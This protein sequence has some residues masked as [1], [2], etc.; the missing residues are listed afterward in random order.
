MAVAF[1]IYASAQ[2]LVPV[3]AWAQVHANSGDALDH[4]RFAND[5]DAAIERARRSV[6]AG[7]LV[8]AIADLKRYVADHPGE[9]APGRYLGDLYYRE[10]DL[11]RAE[12]TYRDIIS[13]A[14]K[15]PATHDRLGGVLAAE[16]RI[17]EAIA[18]F[19]LSLPEGAAYGSLV[20]LHRRR[21]DLDRFE[22]DSRTL[23]DAEPANARAQYAIGTILDAEHHPEL[24]VT[25]LERASLLDGHSCPALTELGSAYSDTGRLDDAEHVLRRCL[26]LDPSSYEATVDLGLVAIDRDRFDEAQTIFVHAN[27]LRPAA[28]EALVDLGYIADERNDWH[29]AVSYYL[30]AIGNNPLARDA[31]V[32]LGSNYEEHGLFA[33]AEAAYLKGLSVSPRDGRL[34]YL[35]GVAYGDQGKRDLA[36]TEYRA[37]TA[38]DEPEVASAAKHILTSP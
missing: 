7:D 4:D 1:A 5:P 21:G 17:A 15:D 14:P 29:L 36:R 38:S 33:L 26:A 28:P 23:A 8:R 35:L 13:I 16:D 24:A 22:A 10:G 27:E 12:R 18:E 19:T 9:L 25:Y 37:A 30:R 32:D 6:A 34:H 20:E 11:A 3:G 2:L 31:Y